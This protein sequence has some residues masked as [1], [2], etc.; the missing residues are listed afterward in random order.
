MMTG[1]VNPFFKGLTTL[2]PKLNKNYLLPFIL[3][4]LDAFLQAFTL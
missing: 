3:K 1:R 2:Y 4:F